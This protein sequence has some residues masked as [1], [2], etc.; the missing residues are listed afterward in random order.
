ML[1]VVPAGAEQPVRWERPDAGQVL[2][3]L[4][5]EEARPAHLAVADDV[6]P[7]LLLVPNRQVDAVGEQ[8]VQV[9]RTELAPLGGV[10]PGREPARVGVGSHDARQERFVTH[11]PT[12]ANENARAGAV[13]NIDWRV[14]AGMPRAVSWSVKSPSRNDRP[15]APPNER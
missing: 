15:G 7:G 8:L 5:R 14:S 10:D 13:T 6:D 2:V 9:G 1:L 11:G 12:S 4:G 3:E